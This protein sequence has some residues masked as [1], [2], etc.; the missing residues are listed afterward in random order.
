MERDPRFIAPIGSASTIEA[1]AT[2][3]A[4][5]DLLV[6]RNQKVGVQ[7]VATTLGIT[8]SRASRHLSNLEELGLV[9]R[10]G[11]RGYELGWRLMRWGHAAVNR[12]QLATMLEEYLVSL[13][14]QLQLTVLLCVPAG[15]DA[16]VV[17]SVA[18]TQAFHIDVKPGA[19]LRLPVSPTARIVMAFQDRERR[20]QLLEELAARGEAAFTQADGQD[21]ALHLADIQR[22][23]FCWTR[24]KF[25]LG[26]GAVAA[27]VF[28]RDEKLCAIVTIML[29][30]ADL[31]PKGPPRAVVDALLHCCSQAMRRLNSRFQFPGE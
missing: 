26:H 27:P 18:P 23:Y 13:C 24:D 15:G 5:I 25:N 11:G 16:V 7:E 10:L 29:A 6:E 28:D 22:N 30:S 4:I 1:V 20:R 14:Q 21:L 2:A 31:T 12:L 17:R 19:V 3:A 8:K 9:N